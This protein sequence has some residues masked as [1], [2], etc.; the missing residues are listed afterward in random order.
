MGEPR[1]AEGS[2]PDSGTVE[3]RAWVRYCTDLAAT[4]RWP[5][6]RREVGWPARVRD[7]S[8]GGIG[9]LLRHRFRPGTFLSVE[10][11]GLA[12]DCRP[13]AVRVVHATPFNPGDGPC[14]LVG[15][16]LLE[17]LGEDELRVLLPAPG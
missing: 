16:I 8:G 9:L 6:G 17:P 12:G 13:L 10:L 15:C 3:R 1:P 11:Q 2:S 14:W 5:D 7:V 4:C